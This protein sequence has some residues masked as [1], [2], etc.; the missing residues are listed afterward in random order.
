MPGCCK[1]DELST[2]FKATMPNQPMQG[3]GGKMR[4]EPREV[5]R[6]EHARERAFEGGAGTATILAF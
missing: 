4:D 3:F 2:G 6:I 5:R 1:G